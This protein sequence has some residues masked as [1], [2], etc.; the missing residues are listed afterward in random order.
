MERVFFLHPILS[1]RDRLI[2]FHRCIEI[3]LSNAFSCCYPK[4]IN[5]LRVNE[6]NCKQLSLDKCH[7]RIHTYVLQQERFLPKRILSTFKK[8]K[9][10]CENDGSKNEGIEGNIR[11]S[12]FEV[13]GE[14][15]RRAQRFP[16]SAPPLRDR[17]R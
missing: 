14:S 15:T 4:D 2:T 6:N 5:F 9:E 16:L 11:A 12:D 8:N 7:K 13:H 10:S 1:S 3:F 17:A